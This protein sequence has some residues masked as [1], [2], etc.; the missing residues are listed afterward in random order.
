VTDPTS[1][2]DVLARLSELGSP[3]ARTGM[4]RYGINTTRAIGV[5]IWDLRRVA[6]RIGTDHELSLRLWDTGIHEGQ[7]LAGIIADPARTTEEQVESWLADLDSW[8]L[9]D[10]TCGN[11]FA[12]LPGASDRALRWSSRPEE[13]VKR[14][15]FALMAELAWFGKDLPDAAFEPFLEAIVRESGDERNFVKK[16]VNWA[17]RNIGKRNAALNA[18][19]VAVASTLKATNGRSARWFGTDALRELTAAKT[20]ARLGISPGADVVQR[21][22]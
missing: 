19:A 8:D 4:A 12:R 21:Q 11:L 7:L 6:K 2:E 10:Q 1:S 9:C 20:L 18:R 17:L 22:C 5:S 3:D 16:A 14:A 15:G 13:F